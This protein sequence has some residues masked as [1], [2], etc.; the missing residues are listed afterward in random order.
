M[1]GATDPRGTDGY[2]TITSPGNDPL[3]I[4]VGAM[5]RVPTSIDHVVKPDLGAPGNRIISLVAYNGA[6]ASNSSANKIPSSYYRA[7]PGANYS[8]DY[9]RLSGTSMAAPGGTPI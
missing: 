2:A 6:I 3:A 9:Y 4:T 7:T 5:K 8:S 1:T